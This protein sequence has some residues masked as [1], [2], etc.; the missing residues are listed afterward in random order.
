ML[1]LSTLVPLKNFSSPTITL[2]QKFYVGETRLFAR[3]SGLLV[4]SYLRCILAVLYLVS[5]FRIHHLQRSPLLM[6]RLVSFLPTSRSSSSMKTA[7]LEPDGCEN[8]V[9]F[10]SA[11]EKSPLDVLV[12]KIQA[13]RISLPTINIPLGRVKPSRKPWK[14]EPLSSEYRPHIKSNSNIFWKLAHIPEVQAL[15]KLSGPIARWDLEDAMGKRM[16]PF[17]KNSAEESASLTDLPS[18]ILR[19]EPQERISLDYL[20]Q[21]AWLAAPVE[22]KP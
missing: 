18:K 5:L 2:F 12:K 11:V 9:D 1:S 16:A 13:K 21:H 20:A 6:G 3:I 17:P 14:M 8:P 19:Y 7:T 4:A 22:S 15:M 10:S